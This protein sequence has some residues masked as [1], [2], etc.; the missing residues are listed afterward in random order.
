MKKVV[1]SGFFDPIHC[2]H[3]EYLRKAKELG[4]Y[5]IV[6]VNSDEA[7]FR[8]KGYCFMPLNE[9]IE[10]IKALK[11]V[12]EVIPA[13]DCDNTVANSLRQLDVQ[14]FAK[15]GDRTIDNIP[16][17]E[18]KVCDE[19]NIEIITGL[20]DKIQSSSNLLKCFEDYK[21]NLLK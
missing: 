6:L 9:R 1:A 7:A 15:G 14:I 10:I 12:D 19:F 8:K 2:G 17:E 4:D 20:G 11:F 13:L 16:Y 3:I 18:K 5:L 21:T